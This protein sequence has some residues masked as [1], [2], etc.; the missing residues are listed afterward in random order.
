[1]QLI[2]KKALKVVACSLRNRQRSWIA[3]AKG[4]R[5]ACS[6]FLQNGEQPGRCKYRAG[7][8]GT[9]QSSPESFPGMAYAEACL[10]TR[11]RKPFRKRCGG[12]LIPYPTAPFTT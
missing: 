2:E 4:C 7:S 11:L 9:I 12:S 8:L 3:V 6:L 5:P 10:Q 1:M